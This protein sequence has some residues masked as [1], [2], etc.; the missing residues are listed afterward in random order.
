[1][2][3][4]PQPKHLERLAAAGVRLARQV[5][6]AGGLPALGFGDPALRPRQHVIVSA[7]LGHRVGDVQELVWPGQIPASSATIFSVSRRA[8]RRDGMA[9]EVS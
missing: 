9:G 5:V 6:Q 7:E 8:R 3:G 2:L 1:M 4:G